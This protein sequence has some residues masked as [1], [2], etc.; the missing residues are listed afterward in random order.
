VMIRFIENTPKGFIYRSG[1]GIT[2]LSD[3]E[4]EYKEAINKVYAPVY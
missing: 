1:G 4:Q 2:A 3:A